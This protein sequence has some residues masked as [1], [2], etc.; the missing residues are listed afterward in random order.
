MVFVFVWLFEIWWILD[1]GGGLAR[2]ATSFFSLREFA[3]GGAL[4][5]SGVP[6]E[7]SRRSRTSP[8][9][10]LALTLRQDAA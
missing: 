6:A 5:G 9:G 10:D 3:L 8:E 4:P 2:V 1:G 7:E